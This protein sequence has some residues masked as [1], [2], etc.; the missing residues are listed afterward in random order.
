MKILENHIYI[1]LSKKSSFKYIFPVFKYTF[2]MNGARAWPDREEGRE[3]GR[4]V[5]AGVNELS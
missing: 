5:G 4:W 3:G 1:F 2:T